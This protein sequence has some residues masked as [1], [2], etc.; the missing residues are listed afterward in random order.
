MLTGATLFTIPS[1]LIVQRWR[2]NMFYDTDQDSILIL[3]F[4]QEPKRARIDLAHANV[5]RQDHAGV[6][7]G[8]DDYYWKPLRS[9]L[10]RSL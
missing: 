6:T 5:P 3:R 10:K 1:Q 2:S 9:Y 4:T 7:K 8:W